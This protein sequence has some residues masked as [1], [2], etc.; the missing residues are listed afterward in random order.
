MLQA[1][2]FFA[3]VEVVGLAAAPLAVLV[4]GRL[5]GAGLGF[6]KP[7]G[8][9]LVT[10]GVWLIAS[11]GVVAYSTGLAV[12]VVAAMALAGVLAAARQ[13]AL[14]ARLR[15]TAAPGGARAAAALACAG[16]GPPRPLADRVDRGAGAARARSGAP[17]AVDRGGGGV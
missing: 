14:G 8:V 6:A 2:G 10:W 7:F 4:F 1:L 5:P 15:S 3:L 13:R 12:A 9:L 11:F 17:L 16:G